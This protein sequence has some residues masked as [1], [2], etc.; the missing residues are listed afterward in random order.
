[1]HL[2]VY[3]IESI[4]KT[5]RDYR[6]TVF[7]SNLS[8]ILYDDVPYHIYFQ[9]LS[10]IVS[11]ASVNTVRGRAPKTKQTKQNSSKTPQSRLI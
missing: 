8:D 5:Y 7:V 1:M 6:H 2:S 9:Y 3:R 11:I 10:I 4:G